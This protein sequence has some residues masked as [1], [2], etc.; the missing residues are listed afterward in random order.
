MENE[1]FEQWYARV[2]QLVLSKLGIGVG[3]LADWNSRGA[4]DDGLEPEDCLEIIAEA[5]DFPSQFHEFLGTRG[6]WKIEV[7]PPNF[8]LPSTFC[9]EPSNAR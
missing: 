6:A 4:Y 8:R 1:T 3:N 5:Q 7:R 9:K 2:D